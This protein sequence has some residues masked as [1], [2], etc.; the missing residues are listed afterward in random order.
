MI[1]D[2]GRAVKHKKQGLV[3]KRKLLVDAHL[4]RLLEL[5]TLLII[6]SVVG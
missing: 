5:L 4:L 6:R 3:P 1:G 2:L